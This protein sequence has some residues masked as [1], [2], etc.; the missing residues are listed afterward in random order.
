M[1]GN[2]TD[3]SAHAVHGT[4]PQFLV[5]KIVREKV[6]QMTFWKERCFGVTAASLVDLAMELRDF[7]G[8]YSGT[9]KATDFLC[10]VLKMLQIQPEKEIVV[11]AARCTHS[12]CAFVCLLHAVAHRC[13]TCT[14]L[15]REL[16][17]YRNTQLQRQHAAAAPASSAC[18]RAAGTRK[19]TLP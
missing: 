18:C 8:V 1:A 3:P 12:S 6:W 2:Q 15:L 17:C 14:R 11:R 4:N 10:L 16:S 13:A 19:C 7:G 5:P 9:N